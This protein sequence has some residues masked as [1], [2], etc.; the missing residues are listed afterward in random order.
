MN[1]YPAEDDLV[2]PLVEEQA[3]VTKTVHET[4][5]V[6]VSTHVEEKAALIREA[7]RH[8]DVV[9]ER[10]AIGKTVEIAPAIRR[11]GDTFV[12]PIVE[13]VLFVEKRLVL[14]EEL[15]IRYLVHTENVEREINL[16]SMHADIVR[17]TDPT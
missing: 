7:L 1:V 2:V 6:Q 17:T 9:I 10:V 14:K 12:Y 13:E 5:R 8:E 11:E 4:G 16:R 3:F 15:R